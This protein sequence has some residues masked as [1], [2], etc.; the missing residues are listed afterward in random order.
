MVA[1]RERTLVKYCFGLLPD[2]IL[3]R[4]EVGRT[5]ENRVFDDRG[6]VIVLMPM[7]RTDSVL[8][9]WERTDKGSPRR[10]GMSE[11]GRDVKF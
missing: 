4:F 8:R 2:W 5:R 6:P 7:V 1:S 9:H 11:D 10:P 3:S